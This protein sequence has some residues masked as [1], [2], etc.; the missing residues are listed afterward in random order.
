MLKRRYANISLI[1]VLPCKE[2][3]NAW[4]EK[5]KEIY[6]YILSQADEVTYTSEHYFRGCMHKRNRRL[7]DISSHCIAYR[8]KPKGGGAYTM[9]YAQKEGLNIINLASMI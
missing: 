6:H 5:E 3:C 7:V 4:D 9:D 8:T 2:Q 1:L